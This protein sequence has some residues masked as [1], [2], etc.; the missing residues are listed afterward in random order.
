MHIGQFSSIFKQNENIPVEIG[1]TGYVEDSAWFD[2]DIEPGYT[3]DQ[4]GR[5]CVLTQPFALMYDGGVRGVSRMMIWERYTDSEDPILVSGPWGSAVQVRSENDAENLVWLL[6]GTTRHLSL[7]SAITFQ[8]R[9]EGEGLGITYLI[10]G[11]R[12]RMDGPPDYMAES[13]KERVLKNI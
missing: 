6:K 9:A 5:T 1:A 4:H 3:T 10:D 2:E 7:N 12:I 11:E 13:D 8:K